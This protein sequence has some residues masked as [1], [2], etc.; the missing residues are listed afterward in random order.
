M[1]DQQTVKAQAME[2]LR[3]ELEN[4]VTKVVGIAS[5]CGFLEF[6]LLAFELHKVRL[7]ALHPDIAAPGEDPDFVRS[8]SEL[9]TDS[10]KYALQACLR[11][12][13]RQG[14]RKDA[15]GNFVV[16]RDLVT[17][18]VGTVNVLN[19]KAEMASLISVF[20]VAQEGDRGRYLRVDV[21]AAMNRPEVR[22]M[23]AYERRVRTDNALR[24]RPKQLDELLAAFAAEYGPYADLFQTEFGLPL[25][26]AMEIYRFLAEEP[27][28]RA[29]AAESSFPRLANGNVDLNNPLTA[30]AYMRGCYLKRADLINRFDAGA[31]PFIDRLTCDPAA[32]N[33]H[34]LRYHAATRKPLLPWSPDELCV[35][36]ELVLD[37]LFTNA[38]Y[39]LLENAT[40]MFRDRTSVAEEYKR[41]YAERFLDAVAAAAAPVGYREVS[42]GIE[43]TDGKRQLGDMDLVLAHDVTGHHLVVEGKNHMLPLPV[44]F[45]DFTAVAARR[46]Q[47]MK[48]WEAKVVGRE[49]HLRHHHARYGLGSDFTYVIVTRQP[50]ILSYCSAVPVLSLHEFREWMVRCPGERTFAGVERAVYGDN[51]PVLTPDQWS[52]LQARGMSVMLDAPPECNAA[53]AGTN[54]SPSEPNGGPTSA[55]AEPERGDG[56]E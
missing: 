44:F 38:H 20:D 5:K 1:M 52:E 9:A 39:S 2:K 41:R 27:T 31:G 24:R 45:M 56:G 48:E 4:D 21:G 26:T 6:Q 55:P 53:V 46:V 54:R 3:K 34:E 35:L 22:E 40:T 49:A 50:E 30:I 18:L 10:I 33:G 19:A 36:G 12:G 14:F 28:R 37:S 29:A 15:G 32:F 23:L 42:R 8:T 43:L 17:E 13:R 16:R 51:E 25:T 47:L 7:E 11:H